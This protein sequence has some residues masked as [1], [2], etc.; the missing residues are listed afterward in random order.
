MEKD[1]KQ[2][3]VGEELV[4]KIKSGELHREIYPG[5]NDVVEI[6]GNEDNIEAFEEYIDSEF[7]KAINK[8]GE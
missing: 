1:K 3:N 2:L 8:R 4:R 7:F 5:R 6:L